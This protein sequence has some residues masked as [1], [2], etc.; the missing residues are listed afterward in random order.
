[1]PARVVAQKGLTQVSTGE[2]EHYADLAGKLRHELKGPGGASGHP[3]VGDWLALRPPTG[4]G[5]AMIHAV[6]PRKTRFSRKTAGQRTEEQVVAANV[7]TIFLVSG[8]DGD[9]NPRRIERY[10]TAAWDSGAQPVVVLNKLDRCAD[11]EACLLEVQAV[12]PW[13][14]PSTAVSALTGEGCDELRAYLGRGRTVA[15]SA[16]RA[17]ASPP[18]INRLLG[19]EAPAHRP[20]C[21]RATTAAGT[22][23]PTA[24][25]SC[26]PAAACSSTPR[27]CA[28]SSSGKGDA[29]HRVRLRRHRG[30]GRELPL[31]R[32]PARGEPGCAVA[33]A[34]DARRAV[35]RAPGELPQAPARA[36]PAPHPP[37]RVGPPAREE[38]EQGDPQS[39]ARALPPEAP[40]VSSSAALE[41]SNGFGHPS[42]EWERSLPGGETPLPGRETPLPSR[43]TPFPSGETPLPGG[44][45]SFP[46]GRG[47]SPGGRRPSLVGRRSSLAG[48]RLSLPGRGLS[49]VG[50]PPEMHLFP[51]ILAGCPLPRFRRAPPL[52]REGEPGPVRAEDLCDGGAP[53]RGRGHR[54]DAGREGRRRGPPDPAGRGPPAA[55]R[56]VGAPGRTAGS[57]GDPGSRG[58]ARAGGRGRAG[59]AAEHVLGCLDDIPR[60]P[61]S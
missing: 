58:P 47:L 13:A 23:P 43:E 35:R 39:A 17:S 27:A 38:E 25:C 24:S 59:P 40:G 20:R 33:A 41:A 42:P 61:A 9:F 12:A 16:P 52:G 44:A 5:R 3:A 2:A 15:S 14:C 37:G 34:V 7:D 21:A 32:L 56:P 57:G 51:A 10:L 22:P 60:V 53:A 28:S 4:E 48:R 8:L 55:W 19:R 49:P 54:H 1:M 29:G 11:P 50:S 6:L 26:S 46:V 45:M 30:A 36:A 18:C 31:Q